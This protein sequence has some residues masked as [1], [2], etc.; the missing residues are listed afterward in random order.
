MK[1]LLLVAVSLVVAIGISAAERSIPAWYYSSPCQQTA[2]LE[3]WLPSLE[4]VPYEKDTYDCSEMSA[5]IEWLTESCGYESMIACGDAHCWVLVEG[6]AFEP[7]G[8][9]WVDQDHTADVDYYSPDVVYDSILAGSEWDWWVV[10]PELIGG[11]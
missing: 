10:H 9:Y 11:K 6:I 7:T 1:A 3:D 8:Q 2:P 4:W 5:Y